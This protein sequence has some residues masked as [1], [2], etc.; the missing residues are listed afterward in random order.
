MRLTLR[1]LALPA[2]LV[3]GAGACAGRKPAGEAAAPV[4]RRP[5]APFGGAQ[6]LVVPAQRLRADDP[7]GWGAQAGAARPFLALLDDELARAVR[8]RG[9]GSAWTFAPDVVRAARRN[10]TLAADPHALAVEPLLDPRAEPDLPA[11]L[12]G[13]LRGL[14]ALGEARYVVVP[15]EL[16]FVKRADGQGEAVLRVA[17]VDA[18]LSRRV[19]AGEVRS[20]PGTTFTRGLLASLAGHFADLI[21]APA[22]ADGA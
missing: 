1:T 13:P 6:L 3:V 7:L 16:R 9:T 15:A 19:W 12:A 20:D 4:V 14:V 17:L 22:G 11:A 5:L 21:A 8:D 18:R 10:P 2:L